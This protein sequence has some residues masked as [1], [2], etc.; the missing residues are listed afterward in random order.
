VFE[1]CPCFWAGLERHF[2]GESRL[3]FV[4]RFFHGMHGLMAVASWDVWTLAGGFYRTCIIFQ[5]EDL[6]SL[7]LLEAPADTWAADGTTTE[8]SCC[9]IAISRE[10]VSADR[11]LM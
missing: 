3:A 2:L 9:S 11:K 6:T 10:L 5:N 8:T 7:H 1:I 4:W